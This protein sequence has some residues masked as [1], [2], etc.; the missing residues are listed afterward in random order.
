MKKYITV[1][2]L[3]HIIEESLKNSDKS[4]TVALDG[5][6]ASGKTTIAAEIQEYFGA[7]LFHADDFFL[8][9]HQRTEERLALP[10]GNFD[11]ERFSEEII[12]GILSGKDFTYRPFDCKTM[13]LSDE[14]NVKANRLNI[15]EGSYSCHPDII[16]NYD[17]TVFVTATK[18]IRRERILKRNK[19]NSEMFFSK[20]IPL[21]ERYFSFFGT[22]DK[23]CYIIENQA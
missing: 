14:K 19:E 11:K 16:M 4:I 7:N 6:S 15:I 22:K 1:N 23:C 3:K 5:P 20:W 17:I 9:P 10:G 8:R 18:E 12:K 2:E 21:E 13:S